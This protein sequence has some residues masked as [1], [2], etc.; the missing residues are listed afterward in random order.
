MLSR[1]VTRFKEH[2]VFV[3]A[4]FIVAA[5]LF[6]IFARGGTTTAPKTLTHGITCKAGEW[7]GSQYFSNDLSNCPDIVEYLFRPSYVNE[8]VSEFILRSP[9]CRPVNTEWLYV[10]QAGCQNHILW[11]STQPIL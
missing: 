9:P 3:A 2:K 10:I 11:M 5:I 4:V 1:T 8:K 7:Q 6:A